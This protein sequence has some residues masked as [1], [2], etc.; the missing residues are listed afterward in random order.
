MSLDDDK[1]MEEMRD[2]TMRFDDTAEKG[3]ALFVLPSLEQWMDLHGEDGDDPISDIIEMVE[4]VMAF[5]PEDPHSIS[6]MSAELGMTLYMLN[7]DG[8]PEPKAD[9]VTDAEWKK[10]ARGNGRFLVADVGHYMVSA[11]YTGLRHATLR[12]ATLYEIGVFDR[13]TAKLVD[14]LFYTNSKR[15]AYHA[16]CAYVEKWTMIVA[17][18]DLS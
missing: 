18:G 7:R 12:E 14:G 1:I 6:K 15:A 4:A 2:L 8:D 13:R 5:D 3:Y 17:E 16:H 11:L 10:N 9:W